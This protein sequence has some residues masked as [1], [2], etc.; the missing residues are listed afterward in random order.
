MLIYCLVPAT[1]VTYQWEPCEWNGELSPA[2]TQVDISL[3]TRFIILV[4]YIYLAFTCGCVSPVDGQ[5]SV[6]VFCIDL[7]HWIHAFLLTE[8]IHTVLLIATAM[9]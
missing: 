8:I 6:D 1:R 4:I 3:S 5:A 9:G 2:N 7:I